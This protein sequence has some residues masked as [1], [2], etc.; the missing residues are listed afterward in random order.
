MIKVNKNLALFVGLFISLG[1][2]FVF[3]LQKFFPFINHISYYCQSLLSSQMTPIPYYLSIIPVFVL[4][5]TLCVAIIKFL[6]LIAKVEYLKH[7]LRDKIT[8]KKS[9]S[10][11]VK[12]LKLEEKTVVI[13]TSEKFA[14]CLGI[15]NPKIYIS[16]GFISQLSKKEIEAVLRHEQYHL[17][18]YD[19]FIMIIASV[20]RS[21]FPFFP[22]IDDVIKKYKIEREIKADRFAIQHL[23]ESST[24]ISTLKKLLSFS[25]NSNILLP[26]VADQDTLEPRIF[27][28]IKREY[29]QYPFRLR[30]F[31]ITIFSSLVIVLFTV[32]PVQAKEIHH[33][34]HDLIMV[35]TNTSCMNSC[36]N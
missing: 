23:G 22:L 16:T 6:T 32:S 7:T 27:S 31:L 2:L 17:E 13:K 30:N 25:T 15:K 20:V 3:I 9:I 21:C 5:L 18:N 36:I 10:D 12:D 28:L 8:V 26:A 4:F 19:T 1:T 35:C 14:Y 29:T 34:Q 11:L 33:D 24:L